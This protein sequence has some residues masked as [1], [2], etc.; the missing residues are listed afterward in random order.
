M[1]ILGVIIYFEIWSLILGDFYVLCGLCSLN[2][3][4]VLYEADANFPDFLC[5]YDTSIFFG[6]NERKKNIL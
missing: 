6:K 5:E 3:F 1:L 4:Y 2:I